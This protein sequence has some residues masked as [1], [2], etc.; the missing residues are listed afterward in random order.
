MSL[1]SGQS[2]AGDAVGKTPAGALRAVA[3]CGLMAGTGVK[4]F[5]RTPVKQR[6]RISDM[7]NRPSRPNPY[8]SFKSDRE[9]R[10]ALADRNRRDIKIAWALVVVSTVSGEASVANWLALWRGLLTWFA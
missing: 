3:R 4:R 2:R 9:R 10:L 5:T 8:C 6:I 7:A 1:D